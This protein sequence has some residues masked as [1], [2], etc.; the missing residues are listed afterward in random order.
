MSLRFALALLAIGTVVM[1][2]HPVLADQNVQ[3]AQK[4]ADKWDSTYNSGNM[5]ELVKLYSPDAIVV[6]KGQPQNGEGIENFFSGLKSK[7][8]DDHK[9]VVK[10]V[11]P[12]G[13]MLIASGRW[14]MSGPG[15]GGAKKKFDGNWVNVLERS[16]NEWRTV[17]HTWN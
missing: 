8:F 2:A 4:A 17:L 5:T 13:N 11:I 10:S 7:G 14:E 16:S 12:K 9:V 1:S 15:E 6:T 3:D